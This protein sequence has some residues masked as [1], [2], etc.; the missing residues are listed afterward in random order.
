MNVAQLSP[1]TL[2]QDPPPGPNPDHI[3]TAVFCRNEKLQIVQEL[4]CTTILDKEFCINNVIRASTFHFMNKQHWFEGKKILY[5]VF[6]E[7]KMYDPRQG[8]RLVLWAEC[9]IFLETI[10]IYN[11]ID[12]NLNQNFQL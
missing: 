12:K 11:D 2:A 10:F 1:V 6:T 7:T 8:P 3:K 5:L 9:Q 4:L